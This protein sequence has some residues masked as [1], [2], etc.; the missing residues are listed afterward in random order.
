[1]CSSNRRRDFKI[2]VII[3]MT[4]C[5]LCDRGNYTQVCDKCKDYPIDCTN[6]NCECCE[7]YNF[8][9]FCDESYCLECEKNDVIAKEYNPE[10]YDKDAHLPMCLN[11]ASKHLEE[12]ASCKQ[13]NCLHETIEWERSD[14]YES[15]DYHGA[16]LCSKC[17]QY[18]C[19][20]CMAKERENKTEEQDE[21]CHK[22]FIKNTS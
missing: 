16:F 15:G 12:C 8:C 5:E 11:C 19:A 6:K 2:K 22:C 7:H 13:V 14:T 4:R 21:W 1:M 20:G 9:A 18:V 10:V 3:T 17:Y